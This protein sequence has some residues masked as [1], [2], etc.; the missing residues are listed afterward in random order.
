MTTLT[1][2][3]I[4]LTSAMLATIGCVLGFA[5]R[6]LMAIIARRN[7]EKA[8][9]GYYWSLQKNR[10]T[11]IMNI[12]LT[13]MLMIGRHELIRAV[14]ANPD[15]VSEWPSVSRVAFILNGAPFWTGAGIGLFGAFILRW[16]ITTIDHRFGRSKKLRQEQASSQDGTGS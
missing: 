14:I 10:I 9:F 7:D 16:V 3:A 1:I 12:V 11:L 4:V 5:V 13:V 2:L 6:E 15:F 8:S